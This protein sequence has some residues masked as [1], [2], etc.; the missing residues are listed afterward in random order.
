MFIFFRGSFLLYLISIIA[1]L[2]RRNL[3]RLWIR[4]EINILAFMLIILSEEVKTDVVLKYFLIQR[5]SSSGII[6]GLFLLFFQPQE[7]LSLVVIL[8]VIL[9]LGIPPFHYWVM[10]LVFKLKFLRFFMF[11]TFQKLGGL[12]FLR[13]LN[14][15]NMIIIF[16]VRIFLSIWLLIWVKSI[17]RLLVVSSIVNIS[18][19]CLGRLYS[20]NLLYFFFLY[21]GLTYFV[22][23]RF[24]VFSRTLLV[25]ER[26]STENI[27]MKLIR[28][29]SLSGIPPFPGFLVKI[30]I[31]R[32]LL[33]S[34]LTM[35]YIFLFIF[36]SLILIYFYFKVILSSSLV[37]LKRWQSKNFYFSKNNF[38]ILGSLSRVV[39]IIRVRVI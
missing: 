11:L 35:R 33:S 25:R 7:H 27:S 18:W 20:R 16:L 29:W 38:F 22:C 36:S 8:S 39:L 5:V 13:E 26:L 14:L 34:P 31:F 37:G 23:L 6:L 30:K 17:K 4:T 19:F 28:L 3:I 21:C 24:F 15:K 12:V 32:R 10:D 1:I 9:K 2:R